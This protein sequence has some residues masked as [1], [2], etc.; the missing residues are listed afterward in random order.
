MLIDC[1]YLGI[2]SKIGMRDMESRRP[3]RERRGRVSR[4]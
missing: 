1:R 4:K 3:G 2:K